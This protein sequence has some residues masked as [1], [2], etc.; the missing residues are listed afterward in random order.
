MLI[1]SVAIIPTIAI[2]QDAEQQ[3]RMPPRIH[4]PLVYKNTEYGFCY[5]LPADWKGY[6]IVQEEWSGG[7]GITDNPKIIHGPVI[8]IRHPKWTDADPYQDIPILVFTPAQWHIKK[9]DGII[10]SA[11][12]V[13][14]DEIGHNSNYY[15]AQWPR[16]VGYTDAK[17][18]RE[19]ENIALSY[20]F[21]APCQQMKSKHIKT[22]VK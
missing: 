22:S 16:W 6:S 12:G 1:V 17:G 2:A 7:I 3:I 13:E 8:V 18:W 20:P 9:T 11:A 4:L 5:R 15:F 14:W 10:I 21:Q 19:V